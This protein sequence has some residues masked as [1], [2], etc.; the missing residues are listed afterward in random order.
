MKLI[1]GRT[2]AALLRERADPGQDLP[3]FL[4]VFEQVCQTVAYA[5]SRGVVHRD[6]KPANVMVGAFGEVQVMD[7]GLAKVLER[8]GSTFSVPGWCATASWGLAKVLEREGGVAPRSGDQPPRH[9]PGLV[10]TTRSAGAGPVSEPGHVLGTPAYMAPEQAAGAAERLDERCDVFGLGAIL[11]EILTGQPPYGGT[12]DRQVFYRAARADLGA[13]FAR[14]DTCGADPELI[15]LARRSLA[16]E[17]AERP[18]DA[19]V[20]AAE[21]AAHR[22][23]MEARL[24][25]AEL[26]QAEARAQAKGERKRRRLTLGLAVSVLLTVLVVGGGLLW[27]QYDRAR[28]EHEEA[29]SRGRLEGSAG[30]AAGEAEKLRERA[31]GLTDNPAQWQ[32]A[33]IA[34]R[35]AARHAQALLAKV[36]EAA[37]PALRQRVADLGEALE[38]DEQDRAL[39]AR[40][41]HIRLEQ[42]TL[43]AGKR[44]FTQ[45]RSFPELRGALEAYGLR[46][47]DT[48]KAVARI[49]GR[50]GPVREQLVAALDFCLFNVDPKEDAGG[51]ALRGQPAFAFHLGTAPGPTL[52]PTLAVLQGNHCL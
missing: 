4:H 29:L 24:R 43:D 26:A 45:W 10:R 19:A 18:R 16:A 17:A 27:Y 5:H 35:A 36:G 25:Q 33:L 41:E 50:P 51:T 32:A 9:A 42:S 52:R 23:S 38:A 28:R 30:A 3:R 31:L 39:V 48:E 13:T 20:L 44:S 47:G 34:A 1:R 12:D 8:E 2:L 46:V 40:V 11:C 15:R 22:E 21:L 7:W 6:L 37:D 14:L 49:G